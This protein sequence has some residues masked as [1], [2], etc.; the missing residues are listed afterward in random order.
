MRF[1]SIFLSLI[2][3]FSLSACHKEKPPQIKSFPIHKAAVLMK[4]VPLYIETIGHVT[5]Y[6]TIDVKSRVEGEITNILFKEGQEVKTNDILFIIDKRPFEIAL[7]SAKAILEEN[8]ANLSL[9]KDKVDRYI[10]L[11]K[12]SYVSQLAFKE[13]TTNAAFYEATVKQNEADVKKAALDLYYCTI[14]SPVNGIAGILQFNQGNLIPA[15]SEKPL[16]TLNQIEPIYV[17]FSI[18]EKRLPEIMEYQKTNKLKVHVSFH[19]FQKESLQGEFNLI[20]NTVNTQTGMIQL[21]GVFSNT[22]KKL[23]PGEYIKTRLILTTQKNGLLVPIEAIEATPK[24]PAL[25]VVKPDNTVQMRIVKIG[26]QID[27]YYLVLE[28][29]SPNEEVVTEGQL[30]LYD[31]AHVFV[32]AE[33]E[34]KP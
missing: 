13:Y 18:P 10:P 31:K 23:W 15:N 8:L 24:G 34:N 19:D 14:C 30:N 21:R 16:I 2:T 7:E 25:F 9:A 33:I 6:A 1:V 3:L 29:V 11:L 12:E 20:D 32:P 17:L 26:Q 5:T 4:D 28:G 27:E 22:D